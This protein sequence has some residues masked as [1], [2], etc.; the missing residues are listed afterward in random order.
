[1]VVD[2]ADAG[3]DNV[4]TSTAGTKTTE[5]SLCADGQRQGGKQK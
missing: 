5:R 1:M 4:S 2:G 3:G